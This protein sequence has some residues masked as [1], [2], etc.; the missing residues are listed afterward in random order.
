MTHAKILPSC[1]WGTSKRAS[2]LLVLG[3]YSITTSFCPVED[4]CTKP[5][6]IVMDRRKSEDGRAMVPVK[7][8]SQAAWPAQ[9]GVSDGCCHAC[10]RLVERAHEWGHPGDCHHRP[11]YRTQAF[12]GC[13]ERMAWVQGSSTLAQV[14]F[15]WRGA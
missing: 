10:A 1:R 2:T 5:D 15:G 4:G 6:S 9:Y 14:I 7:R 3:T 8:V 12:S 11:R 13:D